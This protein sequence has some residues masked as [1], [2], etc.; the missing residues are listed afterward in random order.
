MGSRRT[1]LGAKAQR[2]LHCWP[3]VTAG[4]V[5]SL[6]AWLFRG[7]GSGGSGAGGPQISRACDHETGVSRG[8]H[9]S[10]CASVDRPFSPLCLKPGAQAAVIR[11]AARGCLALAARCSFGRFARQVISPTP[12]AARPHSA[13][14]HRPSGGGAGGPR[15]EC[16]AGGSCPPAGVAAAAGTCINSNKSVN[17]AVL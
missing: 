12:G 17:P 4:A 2:C 16:P 8:A 3:L 6:S 5:S 15:L 1:P 7:R 9:A 14:R 13:R 11:G 10:A